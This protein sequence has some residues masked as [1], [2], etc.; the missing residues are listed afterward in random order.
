VR[1]A[2]ESLEGP[3]PVVR[4]VSPDVLVA[5]TA[6]AEVFV[7]GAMDALDRCAR[8]RLLWYVEHVASGGVPEGAVWV[9]V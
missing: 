5:R 3:Q 8:Q 9:D 6:P 7:A 2:A 4:S 1:Q